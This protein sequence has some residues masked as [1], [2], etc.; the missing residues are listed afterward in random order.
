MN[1]AL[2]AA[3]HSAAKQHKQLL[4]QLHAAGAF[5][6]ESAVA[7]T[8]FGAEHKMMIDYYLKRG[9][10][11]PSAGEHIY[12]DRRAYEDHKAKMKSAGIWFGIIF[13]LSSLIGILLLVA[14]KL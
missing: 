4:E 9:I 1:P 2:Q 11:K 3:I 6:R 12:L 8:Q 5:S 14:H 10:L 13:G 7:R